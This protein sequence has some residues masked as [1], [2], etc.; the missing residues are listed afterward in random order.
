MLSVKY[1]ALLRDA[2]LMN[3]RY[4]ILALALSLCHSSAWAQAAASNNS[5]SNPTEDVL[6]ELDIETDEVLKGFDEI[7]IGSRVTLDPSQYRIGL[8]LT[9]TSEDVSF[10]DELGVDRNLTIDSSISYGLRKG[11]EISASL[12]IHLQRSSSGS[13]DFV[14]SDE[15]DVDSAETNTLDVIDQEAFSGDLG[16]M[17]IAVTQVLRSEKQGGPEL[18]GRASLTLPTATAGDLKNTAVSV[19]GLALWNFEPLILT[20]GA[21]ITHSATGDL[22]FLS[23][24]AG[25]VFAVNRSVALG[26]DVTVGSLLGEE[27]DTTSEIVSM[28]LD[29]SVAL[30]NVSLRPRLE[31]GLSENAP[32]VTL[33]FG[34]FRTFR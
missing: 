33:S 13:L 8:G 7:F 1:A 34:I 15:G 20:T 6:D 14:Q 31:I 32:D 24:N 9:Y 16:N 27:F 17:N 25:G 23:I 22:T 5:I 26:A 4:T 18:V 29:A 28:G 12:P 21:D 3:I 19:S 2:K 30:K 10:F 11:T